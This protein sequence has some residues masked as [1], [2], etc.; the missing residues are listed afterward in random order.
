MGQTGSHRRQ[1]TRVN[2]GSRSERSRRNDSTNSQL[3]ELPLISGLDNPAIGLLP[4]AQTRRFVVLYSAWE[5][6]ET[7]RNVLDSFANCHKNS[8]NPSRGR[9]QP[10][11]GCRLDRESMQSTLDRRKRTA[12]KSKRRKIQTEKTDYQLTVAYR[13]PKLSQALTIASIRVV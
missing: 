2:N 5:F 8:I 12:Q 3:E 1:L 11:K 4:L 7:G 9:K 10:V 6:V 13:S